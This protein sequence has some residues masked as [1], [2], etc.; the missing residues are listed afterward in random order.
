[1]SLPAI[2]VVGGTGKLGAALARRW[3]RAGYRVLIGSRD[4]AKA[5]STARQ[6]AAE[7][8]R[9]V[10]SGTNR[11][12][13]SQAEIIVVSVPF[14]AQAGTLGEIH[15]AAAGK[16]VVDTTVPLVPP[17]VMRVQLPPEGCAAVRAQALL[18]SATTVVSAFH[19]V[20]AH[21]IATDE[22]VDCDVLV[23]GD[24]RD[25]RATVIELANAAGTRGVDG[26]PLANS[27]AAEAL[28][29]VLIG[30]NRRYKIVAGIR[31]T[32]LPEVQPR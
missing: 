17:K 7:L 1:M 14:A 21:K 32:G 16:L 2:A 5:A 22:A 8:G 6:V 31:I 27:V 20:A 10:E 25:A 26:G 4:A 24:D 28:T 13:A 9:P 30:I 11:E 23:F 3:V 19:N 12:V 29:A 15:E 18:G